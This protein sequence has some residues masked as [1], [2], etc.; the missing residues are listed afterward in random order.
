ME[1]FVDSTNFLLI[2]QNIFPG[3]PILFMN[4]ILIRILAW[5]QRLQKNCFAAPIDKVLSCLLCQA[6]DKAPITVIKF[7]QQSDFHKGQKCLRD[8][9]LV[10]S[11]SN[12]LSF[13]PTLDNEEVL[14]LSG[15]MRQI[16]ISSD[17]KHPIAILKFHTFATI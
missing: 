14:R 12:L 15:R 17:S 8:R 6:I 1:I 5:C 10:K 2:Q 11:L 4:K 16:A 13:S 3:A 9:L 7:G